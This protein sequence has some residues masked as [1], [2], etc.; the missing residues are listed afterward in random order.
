MADY[1]NQTMSGSTLTDRTDR[2]MT[3][4][5]TDR[6]SADRAYEKLKDRGFSDKDINVM[7]SN[8]TRD[9]HFTARHDS[10]H[11]TD[12]GNKAMEKAGVGSAIGGTVGAVAAAIA[13]IGTNLL[14][15]GLGLV[16]AGPL[17]AGLAGAG[18]GGLTGGLIG[19]LVGSGI[20]E[21]RAKTYE[22]GIKQGGIL[23]GVKARD[24]DD[25]RYLEQHGFH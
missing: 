6:D 13:A 7:M 4:L 5:F 19:A 17:A 9:R 23:I 8:E 16:V 18:A 11:D 25:V 2:V 22:S 14:L 1:T 20:P 10:Q 21:E 3:A 15:P 12:L 24:V